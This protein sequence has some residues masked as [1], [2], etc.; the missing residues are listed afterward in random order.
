VRVEYSIAGSLAQFS[1]GGIVR[2]LAER[3]TA[4]FSSNLQQLLASQRP[5]PAATPASTPTSETGVAPAAPVD[6]G[7]MFWSVL[8]ARL[9]RWFALSPKRLDD[10]Q[11]RDH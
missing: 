2:D 3:M 9:K 1:R 10:E 7:R 6:L 5:E 8:I 4:Q 11:P